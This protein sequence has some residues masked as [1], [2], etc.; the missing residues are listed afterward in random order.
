MAGRVFTVVGHVGLLP[1]VRS[2][3]QQPTDT[4]FCVCVNK[5]TNKR[6]EE[7]EGNQQGKRERIKSVK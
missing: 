5:Q 4:L 7:R 6:M 3:Q 1:D 2:G